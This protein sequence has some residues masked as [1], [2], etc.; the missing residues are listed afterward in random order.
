METDESE[1][2]GMECIIIRSTK[3]FS[4][5]RNDDASSNV[6]SNDVYA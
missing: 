6:L 2:K 1:G 5:D 4:I 3:M